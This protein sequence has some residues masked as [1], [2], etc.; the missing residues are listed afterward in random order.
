MKGRVIVFKA[1][2]FLRKYEESL[3][4]M[5]GAL[6]RGAKECSFTGGSTRTCCCSTLL[7]GL[8]LKLLPVGLAF[9]RMVTNP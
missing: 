1:D 7:C 3:L 6:F 5:L 9:V 2:L 4:K 8:F